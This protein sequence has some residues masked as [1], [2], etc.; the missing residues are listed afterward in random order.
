MLEYIK[1]SVGS[2]THTLRTSDI[3]FQAFYHPFNFFINIT[4]AQLVSNHCFCSNFTHF[5]MSC[6]TVDASLLR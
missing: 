2:H 1:I 6:C 4:V 3:Y 5:W